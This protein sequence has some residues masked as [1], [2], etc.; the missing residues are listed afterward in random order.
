MDSK[1][2]FIL[3]ILI[4]SVVIAGCVAN[5]QDNQEIEDDLQAQMSPEDTSNEDGN[6]NEIQDVRIV[7]SEP[8]KYDNVRSYEVYWEWHNCT[9]DLLRENLGEEIKIYCHYLSYSGE[10]I[11]VGKYYVL[12][13][14]HALGL[15]YVDIDQIT[16]IGKGKPDGIND[17]AE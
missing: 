9:S 1:K 13:D 17:R 4:L 3:V 2:I 16:A 8:I 7:N 14:D 6:E 5:S 10:L 12:L 15:I 11:E